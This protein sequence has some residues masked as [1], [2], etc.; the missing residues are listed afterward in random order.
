VEQC[1]CYN[2][3]LRKSLNKK[4]CLSN[5]KDRKSRQSQSLETFTLDLSFVNT[6]GYLSMFH[7][8]RNR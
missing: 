3:I 4:H 2:F 8:G 5:R 6:S 1:C 7:V